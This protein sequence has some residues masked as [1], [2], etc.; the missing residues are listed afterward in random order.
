MASFRR[1]VI[2]A[3]RADAAAWERNGWSGAAS[4][5]GM[6]RLLV[7]NGFRATALYRI[8]HWAHRS[9]IPF[10][11][12]LT[13]QLNIALHGIELPPSVE[14]GPGLYL[15]HTVGTVIFAE[16]VG[17]DVTMQG[18]ITLGLRTTAEFPS[19]GDGVFLSAGC[20][21]LGPVTVG[22]GA[23]VGANAVVLQDVPPGYV[24]LG[25]PATVRPGR[26]AEVPAA[27]SAA[28]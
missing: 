26:A 9:R 3:L 22:D 15:P 10:L 21:V 13:C 23:V 28:G 14:V 8:G 12:M 16:K 25:V 1:T 20:R 4:G 11:P 7:Q 24:A 19:I 5:R 17:R 6:A 18:G 27:M 2:D